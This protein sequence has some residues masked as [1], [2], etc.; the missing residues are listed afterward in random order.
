MQLRS[1]RDR[2]V[3]GIINFHSYKVVDLTENLR[4]DLVFGPAQKFKDIEA[5]DWVDK[6]PSSEGN[7][8]TDSRPVES[9]WCHDAADLLTRRASGNIFSLV[10]KHQTGIGTSLYSL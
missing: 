3:W 9:S 1:A 5:I 10:F 7:L 8:K 2:H 6:L 4:S